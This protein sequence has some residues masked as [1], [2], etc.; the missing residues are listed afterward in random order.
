M[1]RRAE[2][3]SHAL[4]IKHLTAAAQRELFELAWEKRYGVQK[5]ARWV[6]SARDAFLQ[7]HG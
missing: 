3:P 7:K 4:P 6:T 5:T 2:L 1:Q